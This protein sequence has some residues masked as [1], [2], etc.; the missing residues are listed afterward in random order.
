[1]NK[2]NPL[3]LLHGA[4]GSKDQ[5]SALTK[6][7]NTQFQI[8]TLNFEG[9]GG[10]PAKRDYSMDHFAENLLELI[11]EK[12]LSKANIFGYSMGGYV[13]LKLAISHPDKVNRIMTMGTKF[14]WTPESA[15]QEAGR[16]NPTIIEEKL[17]QFA[18]QLENRHA[19]LDWHQVL[20]KTVKMMVNLGNGEALKPEDFSKVRCPVLLTVG[21]NDQMVSR[22]E[23]TDAAKAIPNAEFHLFEKFSHPLERIDVQILARKIK[24]FF[25]EN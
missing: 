12:H 25:R 6:E 7:L 14:A 9:H 1:M 3:I 17:P 2:K 15:R 22:E 20:S 10:L 8:H 24:E 4:L 21:G 19:P 13:A 5:F 16:L 23:T 18:K 11:A